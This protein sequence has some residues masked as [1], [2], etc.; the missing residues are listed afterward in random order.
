MEST[1]VFRG[2][3]WSFKKANLTVFADKASHQE[4]YTRKQESTEILEDFWGLFKRPTLKSLQIRF[5]TGRE[6]AF[7]EPTKDFCGL[8]KRNALKSW[9]RRLYTKD[10]TLEDKRTFQSLF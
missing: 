8:L 4:W 3:L 2:L 6:E 7:L 9:L 1:E 10:S 5:H